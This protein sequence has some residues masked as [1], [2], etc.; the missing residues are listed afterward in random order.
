MAADF[1]ISA[2][3]NDARLAGGGSLAGFNGG[4]MEVWS[5]GTTPGNEMPTT[6]EGAPPTG[7][8]LAATFTFGSPAGALASHVLVLTQPPDALILT[9]TTAYWV[10][11]VDAEE[12]AWAIARCKLDGDT[13]TEASVVLSQLE[14]YLGG[15][16]RLVSCVLG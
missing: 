7:A 11:F 2:K 13:V 8:L 10:R 3:H 16:V 1:I 15:S 6:A 14:L 4:T 5:A 12:D 9:T